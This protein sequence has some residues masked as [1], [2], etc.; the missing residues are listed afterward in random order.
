MSSSCLLA[1]RRS[2]NGD[3]MM[4]KKITERYL[5]NPLNTL[6]PNYAVYVFSAVEN[7][8]VR[9]VSFTLGGIV[10]QI[11]YG[12]LFKINGSATM[13]TYVSNTIL[14]VVAGLA[15]V[16][17]LVPVYRQRCIDKQRIRLQKQF[18]ALLDSLSASFASGSNVI[19][20]LENA[21]DDLMIQ[22]TE[23]DFIVRE[24]QEILD[25]YA[26]NIGTELFLNDFGERSANDNIINFADVFKTCHHKGGDM[27]PI[28]ICTSDAIREKI[29]I[30]DEIDTKLTS[31][32]MQLNVMSLMPI[33]LVGMLRLTNPMFAEAFT[34][35]LGVVINTIAI[36]IFIGGYAC[37]QKIV[38]IKG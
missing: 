23:Q 3:Y 12:N 18:L 31:N 37:G 9:L 25:G 34:T 27:Q 26:Q 33:V 21:R 17:F 16:K 29:T 8:V 36:C 19:K 35:F 20:A 6:M 14:F 7:V 4:T 11:F 5:R 13:A 2:F 30:Q 38:A 22:Y 10:S 28:I 15:A 32:K 1:F 24:V